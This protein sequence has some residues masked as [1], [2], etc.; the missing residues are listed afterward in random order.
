MD[1]VPHKTGKI[2]FFNK[3]CEVKIN[4]NQYFYGEQ[5][6]QSKTTTLF[7]AQSY[8]DAWA[9]YERSLKRED[10]PKWDYIILTASNERQA[11]AL[12]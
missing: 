8:Q 3:I 7:P 1:I 11:P 12:R 9:D 6:M 10:F 2:Y 5:K 4:E